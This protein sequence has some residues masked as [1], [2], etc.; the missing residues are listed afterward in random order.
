MDVKLSSYHVVTPSFID[1]VDQQSKR[2]VFSTRT[3]EVRV[4]NAAAWHLLES[5]SAD[6]LPPD[7]LSDFVNI[8]LLVPSTDNELSTIL[9]RAS[10]A[11]ID[12]DVL[13]LVIQP[14]ASCQLGC[15]YCGQEH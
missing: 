8:E 13:P 2:V 3:A 14:T 1:E 12:S 4:I 6:R 15:S 5:N 9:R 11:T 10:A 7:I